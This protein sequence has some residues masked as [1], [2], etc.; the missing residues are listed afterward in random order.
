LNLLAGHLIGCG[1]KSKIMWEFSGI[2]C[3]K[4]VDHAENML[5]YA[6]I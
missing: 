4:Y 5:D 2:S 1:N 3:G 6:E